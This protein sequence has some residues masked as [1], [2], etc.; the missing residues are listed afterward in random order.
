MTNTRLLLTGLLAASALAF[1]PM[2]QAQMSADNWY[3]GVGAGQGK[4]KDACSDI[5]SAGASVGFTVTSCD[6]TA[7]GYRLFAGFPIHKN[8]RIEFG[9]SDFG[10]AGGSGV[11]LSVPV[12][13]D[14]KATAWDAS[15]L[16]MLPVADKLS[17]LG[18]LGVALWA[19]D[20]DVNAAGAG[21][22]ESANGA[23]ALYGVGVQYDFTDRFGLRGEWARYSN[24]GDSNTTG[25]TDVDVTGVSVLYRFY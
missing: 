23:S 2:A 6:D 16:G 18:R 1:S 19:V 11:M 22:S 15:V 25:Q 8:F 17:V 21:L 10:K 20:L 13:A 24:V 4:G 5:A 12:S 9:Y 7:N 3:V 14:W